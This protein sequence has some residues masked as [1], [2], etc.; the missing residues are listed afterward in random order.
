MDNPAILNWDAGAGKWHQ[1]RCVASLGNCLKDT[2]I[3]DN[4]AILNWDAGFGWVGIYATKG[5]PITLN[6]SPRN[7][8]GTSGALIGLGRRGRKKQIHHVLD[9]CVPLSKWVNV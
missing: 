6:I 8:S 3:V 1:S 9:A 7:H 5:P 2:H 4:S